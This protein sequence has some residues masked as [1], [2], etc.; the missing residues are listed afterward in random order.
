M[1]ETIVKVWG[2][3]EQG[4]L[5][6]VRYDADWSSILRELLQ[7]PLPIESNVDMSSYQ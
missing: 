4:D 5:V 6:S 2:N 3:G 1:F 7:N